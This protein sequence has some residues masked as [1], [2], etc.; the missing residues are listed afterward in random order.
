ME[1]G[2]TVLWDIRR[3]VRELAEHRLVQQ[4]V[5]DELLV[6]QGE[7]ETW[8]TV[9]AHKYDKEKSLQVEPVALL[10]FT[11]QN[12]ACSCVQKETLPKM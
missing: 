6:L 7:D 2:V 3:H 10:N 9:C 1:K 4:E 12:L 5:A 11:L 8:V